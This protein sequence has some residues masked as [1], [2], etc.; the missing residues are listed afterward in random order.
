MFKRGLISHQAR[1]CCT[2]SYVKVVTVIARPR[3]GVNGSLGTNGGHSK[4][5]TAAGKKGSSKCAEAFPQRLFGEVGSRMED[6][7][8][9][10]TDGSNSWKLSF[11]LNTRIS[12]LGWLYHKF[13]IF[14]F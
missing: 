10:A 2:C 13:L 14:F 4:S 9:D 12:S 7:S 5:S 8:T 6:S 11:H 3:L 1:W